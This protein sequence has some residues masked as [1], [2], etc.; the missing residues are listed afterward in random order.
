MN[1]A[2]LYGQFIMMQVPNSCDK[3]VACT[4]P[5]ALKAYTDNGNSIS[6]SP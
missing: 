2:K 1:G 6:Y 3:T 4:S 5:S